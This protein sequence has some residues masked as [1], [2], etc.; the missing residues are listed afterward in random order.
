ML[1]PIKRCYVL[2]YL[3]NEGLKAIYDFMDKKT[4]YVLFN[5]K[6]LSYPVFCVFLLTVQASQ[7]EAVPLI[8]EPLKMA[9]SAW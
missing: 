6:W 2:E 5:R 8:A 4:S 9:K 7:Q 1:S 3:W